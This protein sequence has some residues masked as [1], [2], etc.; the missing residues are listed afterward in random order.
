[1]MTERLR[2]LTVDCSDSARLDWM[3]R[4]VS[5]V[6]LRRMGIVYSSGCTRS[7][8][9]RAMSPNAELSDSRPL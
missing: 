2:T 5:G 7:D 9:D 6:E 4:N 8:V 1:M 3:M